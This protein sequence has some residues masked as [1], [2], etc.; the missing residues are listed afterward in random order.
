MTAGQQNH[1]RRVRHQAERCDRKDVRNEA[2]AKDPMD[3]LELMVVLWQIQ[4]WSHGAA[5][6][7]RDVHGTVNCVFS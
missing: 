3:D 6:Q 4:H 1:R 2:F 5:R 7:V